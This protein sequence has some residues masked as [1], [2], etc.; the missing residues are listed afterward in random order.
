MLIILRCLSDSE[1]ANAWLGVDQY[2]G[3]IEHA[4]MH[5]LY[6]RFWYKFMRDIGLVKGNEPFNRLLTQGMVLANS[7]ESRELKKFY[8]QEQMNNK[9]YEKDGLKKED[10]IVK[11]EKMSKSKAN[12]VDPAEIIELSVLMLLEYLLCSLL[13]LKKI[14]N[15]LM[16]VLKV[17]QDF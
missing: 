1:A 2:I 4:C 17:L 10:I 16:K 14:K 15:G 5:L 3:G 11:M 7:Y 6:S 9:E 12:G 8:T 13:L